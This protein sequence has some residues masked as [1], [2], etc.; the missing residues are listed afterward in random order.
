MDPLS[1]LLPGRSAGNITPHFCAEDHCRRWQVNLEPRREHSRK[2]AQ[3]E[4]SRRCSPAP[5]PSCSRTQRPGWA[6]WSN[7]TERFAPA[8][9]AAA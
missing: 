1:S 2:A 5:T 4:R 6:S 9:E 3:Y 7:E 8:L